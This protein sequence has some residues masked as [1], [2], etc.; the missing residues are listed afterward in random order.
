MGSWH[1][2]VSLGSPIQNINTETTDAMVGNILIIPFQVNIAEMM[3]HKIKKTSHNLL[4][5]HFFSLFIKTISRMVEI[6]QVNA[7]FQ[8]KME[9]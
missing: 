4:F 8:A 6:Q 2:L 1:N 9:A 7:P 3:A 5:A